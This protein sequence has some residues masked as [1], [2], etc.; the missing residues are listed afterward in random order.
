MR[1]K[2]A[3]EL[4]RTLLAWYRA[5]GR[6]FPWRRTQ[7]PYRILVSEIMLQ[8]TQTSR[9]LEKYPEFI[10]RFPTL[11][12][13]ARARR[14]SVILA[15]QGMGY[16]NRAVRLHSLARRIISGK[17]STV[18]STRDTLMA[19]PGIGPYT[20]NAVLSFAFHRR[21][22]VVETNIRRVLSRILFRMRRSSDLA[23]SSVVWNEAAKLL[24]DRRSY[25]WNQALMDLGATICTA[26]N[27]RCASCPAASLCASSGT[28]AGHTA[29]RTKREPSFN[30][31][32]NRIYRGR[33]VEILRKSGE[34]SGVPVSRLGSDLHSGFRPSDFHWLRSLLA[35]LERDGLVRLKS[36][37]SGSSETVHL[38]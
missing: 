20:A 30:G 26:R 13:L 3:G 35:S 18:P 7:D 14:R 25:D 33:V 10:R 21:V 24:P 37:G 15:W 28:M 11:K 12:A 8:Q 32:P 4:Q 23:D 36:P 9:V 17:D 27:P 38:A 2:T 5:E 19:L 6:A 22:P 29:P 1:K 34:R 31:I 16:N